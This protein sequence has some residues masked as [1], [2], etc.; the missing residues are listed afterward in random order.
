[1]SRFYCPECNVVVEITPK[2][3]TEVVSA[4]CLKHMRGTGTHER[5]GL[6]RLEHFPTELAAEMHAPS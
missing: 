4:H 1:M 2:Y 3:G 5:T 6:V